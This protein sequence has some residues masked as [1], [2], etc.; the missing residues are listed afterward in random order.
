[1]SAETVPAWWVYIVECADGSLYTGSARDVY[2]RLTAHNAGRGA[3]Y[4]RSHSPVKLVYF[5]PHLTQSAAFKREAE[6]KKLPRRQ[7]QQLVAQFSLPL[8]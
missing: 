6:I 5:E 7:K 3:R 2:Q 8:T 1:M 4:T